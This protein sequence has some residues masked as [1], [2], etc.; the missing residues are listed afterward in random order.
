MKEKSFEK[1]QTKSKESKEC[2]IE[3]ILIVDDAPKNLE[4]AQK[5][6]KGSDVRR[7][8]VFCSGVEEALKLLKENKFDCVL[9]D[10]IMPKPEDYSD[11]REKEY[12]KKRKSG[13]SKE[14]WEIEKQLFEEL[15]KDPNGPC[16][17]IIVEEAMARRIP[18]GIVSFLGHH[19]KYE[20]A[21]HYAAQRFG[22]Y[23]PK[24]TEN[25]N[26]LEKFKRGLD[27][28]QISW[29]GGYHAGNRFAL[30]T[31]SNFDS[32]EEFKN[33]PQNWELALQTMEAFINQDKAVD[34]FKI[35]E[36]GIQGRFGDSPEASK[37]EDFKDKKINFKHE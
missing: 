19:S 11:K 21:F 3:N 26:D 33:D 2:P 12:M 25:L 24:G 14:S 28:K 8:V 37:W 20:W 1:E 31:N 17:L 34:S 10:M 13:F 35:N 4:A 22:Y 23:G 5:F 9:T 15:L 7:N 30:I 27:G 16:G 18:V 29:S 6:F 32:E 36:D